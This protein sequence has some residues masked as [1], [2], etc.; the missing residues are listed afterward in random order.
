[1]KKGRRAWDWLTIVPSSQLYLIIGGGKY[2]KLKNPM[3][4]LYILVD[5]TETKSI[6]SMTK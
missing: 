3:N 2:F 6:S 4:E 1:M 5:V